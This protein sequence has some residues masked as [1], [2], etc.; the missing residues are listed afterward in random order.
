MH[1]L[2]HNSEENF[3]EVL[4][5]LFASIPTKIVGNLAGD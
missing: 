2:F 4:D 5:R 3:I 1:L